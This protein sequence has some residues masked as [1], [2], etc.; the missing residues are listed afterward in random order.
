MKRILLL[1]IVCVLPLLAA[2]AAA[3]TQ[4]ASEPA[5]APASGPADLLAAAL[6]TKIS[7]AIE[8]RYPKLAAAC[9]TFAKDWNEREAQD[10]QEANRTPLK[11]VLRGIL[12][13]LEQPELCRYLN[14]WYRSRTVQRWEGGRYPAGTFDSVPADP[15]R[16]QAYAIFSDGP[17]HFV[18]RFN[19]DVSAEEGA[20]KE[21]F[22]SDSDFA[23]LAGAA[24]TG[25]ALAAIQDALD[26]LKQKKDF[27][28]FAAADFKWP[29]GL[30]AGWS[31]I[32]QQADGEGQAYQPLEKELAKPAKTAVIAIRY[33]PEG[34]QD[35]N[36]LI[37]L[38]RQTE[39]PRY[40]GWRIAKAEKTA[41][42]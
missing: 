17:Q 29:L 40:M 22:W 28:P 15:P 6:E 7:P 39:G 31:F 12:S 41:D 8:K 9:E 21:E 16:K 10:A 26:A 20:S 1:T 19:L 37:H 42:P 13:P 35:A 34:G 24:R 23:P 33:H 25:A 4:P 11:I 18:V 38:T 36:V 27:A 32:E 30:P 14:F 3:Q 2:R 5:S